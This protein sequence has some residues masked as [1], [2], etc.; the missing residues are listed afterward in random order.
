MCLRWRQKAPCNPQQRICTPTSSCN[1]KRARGLFDDF[2]FSTTA[3]LLEL[4][5][6]YGLLTAAQFETEEP[7]HGGV[8]RRPSCCFF[9]T[10]WLRKWIKAVLHNRLQ[11]LSRRLKSRWICSHRLAWDPSDYQEPRKS[12]ASHS[13]QHTPLPLKHFSH[14]VTLKLYLFILRKRIVESNYTECAG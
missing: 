3:T 10:E 4:Q 5:H 7:S 14:L 12:L 11:H 1:N 2:L 8:Q 9:D 6:L 13:F